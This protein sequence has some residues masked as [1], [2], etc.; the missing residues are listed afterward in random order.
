MILIMMGV[1]G[2]GKTTVGK[3]LAERLGWNFIEGDECHSPENIHKMRQGIPLTDEDR[4]PWVKSLQ[5]IIIEKN[6]M[7]EDAIIACSALQE[8]HRKM[9]RV[10]PVMRFVYLQGT[11]EAIEPRLR[12]RTH[13]FPPKL[14]E[15]QF[16]ILE[17]PKDAL[18][19]DC[20]L[21]PSTIVDQIVV[22]V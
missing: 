4:R 22:G 11:K 15:S 10:D 2:S 9:L 19:I 18:T 7:N 20:Q 16:A 21:P 3:L 12:K 13:F 17:E 1:A 8:A 14:L 6:K 5:S